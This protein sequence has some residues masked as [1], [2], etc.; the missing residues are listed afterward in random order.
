MDN[1]RIYYSLVFKEYIRKYKNIEFIYNVPCS[2]ESN[3]I[4]K[5]FNELKILRITLRKILIY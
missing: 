4:E 5:V 3:P 2:P 1:C